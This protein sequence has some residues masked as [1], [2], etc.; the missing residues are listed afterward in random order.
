MESSGVPG[1]IQI[2]GSTLA[3]LGDAYVCE[4][5]GSV[6]VKGKGQL[7]TFLLVGRRGETELL[8]GG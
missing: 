3:L 5:R 7:D 4:P 1:A 8:A 2:T 6:D